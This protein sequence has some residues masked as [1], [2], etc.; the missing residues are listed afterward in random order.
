MLLFD[1]ICA[2]ACELHFGSNKTKVNSCCIS[3]PCTFPQIPGTPGSPTHFRANIRGPGRR[4]PEHRAPSATSI[5]SLARARQPRQ[6]RPR[7]AAIA[8]EHRAPAST[9]R[10]RGNLGRQKLASIESRFRRMPAPAAVPQPSTTRQRDRR[11]QGQ[12]RAPFRAETAACLPAPPPAC[13]PCQ[14]APTRP[15][16]AGG[17]RPPRKRLP[18]SASPSA[19]WRRRRT[20]RPPSRRGRMRAPF[21]P[22]NLAAVRQPPAL[23]LAR[24][25][26]LEWGGGTRRS[27]ARSSLRAL[28]R[29]HRVSAARSHARRRSAEEESDPTPL[30]QPGS[31]CLPA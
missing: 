22:R 18:S 23:R 31:A 1:S 7:A 3:F 24:E 8:G 16:S 14:R 30:C 13:M 10:K 12:M 27:R 28:T 2:I 25:R 15:A 26:A 20:A 6:P 19:R 5:A 21:Q 11:R 4:K 17:Q 29:A 9:A